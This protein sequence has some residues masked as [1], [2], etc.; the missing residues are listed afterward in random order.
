MFKIELDC[1]SIE[2]AQEMG[3]RHGCSV[4]V[5]SENGPGGGNPLMKFIGTYDEI[6]SLVKEYDG[7][8]DDFDFIMSSV[9]SI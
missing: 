6:S 4:E 2:G 8:N 1:V 3:R 9:E 5:I 7:L